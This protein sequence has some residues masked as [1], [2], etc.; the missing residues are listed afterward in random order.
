MSEP[1]PRP[2]RPSGL[3]ACE[4]CGGRQV[5]NLVMPA[6][7]T[8]GGLLR[9][10]PGVGRRR[11]STVTGLRAFVCLGCGRVRLFADDLEQLRRDVAE[12]PDSYSW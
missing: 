4:E 5:G 10:M 7:G 9:M 3:P 2:E 11:S 6:A 12:H 8:W 1:A